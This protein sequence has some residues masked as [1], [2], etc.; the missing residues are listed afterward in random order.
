MTPSCV[1]Q[2]EEKSAQIAALQDEKA[3]TAQEVMQKSKVHMI[4]LQTSATFWL[5]WHIF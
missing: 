3:Q 4:Y 1:F 5:D 2:I